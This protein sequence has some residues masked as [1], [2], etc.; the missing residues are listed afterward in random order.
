VA[1]GMLNATGRSRLYFQAELLQKITG[2]AGALAMVR[3]GIPAMLISMIVV[4]A[5]SY[6]WTANLAARDMGF[7]F[8]RHLADSTKVF[9]AASVMGGCAWGIGLFVGLPVEV[10]LVL[11]IV[12]GG[13]VYVL[14]CGLLR[15]SEQVEMLT[16]AKSLVLR[17]FVAAG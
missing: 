2:V 3:I 15:V 14:M 12:A 4:N 6:L 17:K 7:P 16:Y 9:M 10:T 1:I 5:A 8:L 13:V 11:Q